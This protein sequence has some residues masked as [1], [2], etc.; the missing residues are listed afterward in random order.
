VTDA[1]PPDHERPAE[2]DPEQTR[3][4]DECGT[5]VA[6]A[7]QSCP[8]CGAELSQGDV[9]VAQTNDPASDASPEQPTPVSRE[10]PGRSN[11]PSEPTSGPLG[12]K[13]SGLIYRRIGAYVIDSVLV[14]IAALLVL[15]AT[16]S[17]GS[18]GDPSAVDPGLALWALVLE[19]LYRWA[20]QATFGFTVGKLA[21]GLRLVGADGKPANAIHILIRELALIG[22]LGLAQMVGNLIVPALVQIGLIYTVIRRPD[23]RSLHDLTVQ[24]R[25]VRVTTS[26]SSEDTV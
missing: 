11:V 15:G 8:N 13:D 10:W 2:K 4:C 5:A 23:R 6:P 14:S 17:L 1:P 3:F 25:V 18:P 16:D 20:M 21:L 22:M 12:I 7:A 24:T 26:D 9:T 19:V